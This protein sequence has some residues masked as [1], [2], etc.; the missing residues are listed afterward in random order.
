MCSPGFARHRGITAVSQG[1][2]AWRPGEG[3]GGAAHCPETPRE[4]INQKSDSQDVRNVRW[5]LTLENRQADN[6]AQ[7]SVVHVQFRKNNHFLPC[8]CDILQN[9]Q[10]IMVKN[11][12]NINVIILAHRELIKRSDKPLYTERNDVG[13]FGELAIGFI[14]LHSSTCCCRPKWTTVHR[15]SQHQCK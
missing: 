11:K 3:R 7:H 4:K 12:P 5:V 8:W 9:F 6:R 13:E 10:H 14:W 1:P 2:S 15:T